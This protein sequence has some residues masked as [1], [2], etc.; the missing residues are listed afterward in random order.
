[1]SGLGVMETIM[2]VREAEISGSNA[3][4][5]IHPLAVRIAHWINAFAMICMIMSGWRI[6]NASPIFNFLHFPSWMTLGGWLGGAIAWHFAAMWLLVL[7]GVAYVTYGLASRH[8]VRSFLPLDP[9]SI[10]QD[11]TAALRFRLSHEQG[12]YNAVQRLLYVVV[13]LLGVTAVCSGLAV[14][15]PVQVDWLAAVFGGYEGARLVHF[16]VMSGIVG[17]VIVHLALVLLVPKTLLPMITGR[18]KVRHG[19]ARR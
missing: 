8:F 13:L 19:E 6:Y 14:W 17:F 15:K 2:S 9:A 10:W 1:M 16:L 7:N 11:F 12:R 4:R 18:A 3:I 5:V